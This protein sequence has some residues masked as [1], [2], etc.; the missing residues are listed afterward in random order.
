[1]KLLHLF[2]FIWSILTLPNNFREVMHWKE[3]VCGMSILKNVQ[4]SLGP[5]F[6][7]V[8]LKRRAG[9]ETLN[10]AYRLFLTADVRVR[11]VKQTIS[12]KMST[13]LSMWHDPLKQRIRY[14]TAIYQDN[15]AAPKK[16]KLDWYQVTDIEE[17]ASWRLVCRRRTSLWNYVRF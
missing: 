10:T 5:L 8:R 16:I 14:N 6:V 7:G 3:K 17:W 13:S 15:G 9:L 11:V 1:M 2:R 12:K 4:N